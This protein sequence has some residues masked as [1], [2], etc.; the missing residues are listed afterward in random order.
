MASKILGIVSAAL[1]AFPA[2]A[3]V[4]QAQNAPEP[5]AAPAAPA[6]AAPAAPAQPR[7]AAA[8]AA[9]PQLQQATASNLTV[10]EL[11]GDWNVRCFA[12]KAVAPCD[13]L[14]VA[15]QQETKQRVLLISI[16]YVPSRDG[17][18]MQIVVPLGVAVSK[19]LSLAAGSNSLNGLK[20]NR[21]ERDGCYVEA[22][23]ANET[24]QALTAPGQ[25]SAVSIQAYADSKAA[26]LPVSLKGFGEAIGKMRT[27]ARQKASPE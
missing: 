22:P 11:I 2:G 16:A 21:C 6:A 9:Q 18:L 8:A 19:G 26:T 10:N 17:Y 27:Y 25:T 14:Q 24:V 4:A 13:V 15:S 3:A 7:P 12:V 5:A 20:F 1:L 23:L